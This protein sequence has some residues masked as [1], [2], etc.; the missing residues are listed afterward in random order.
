M[1]RAA[2]DL[3][4]PQGIAVFEIGIHQAPE[5]AQMFSTAGFTDIQVIKDWNQI[6]RIVSGLKKAL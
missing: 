5:V 4:A 3:L 1:L 6:G 2:G